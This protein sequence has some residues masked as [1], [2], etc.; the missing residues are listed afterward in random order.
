MVGLLPGK[1]QLDYLRSIPRTAAINSHL[2]QVQTP[3]SF[4]RQFL[5]HTD[6]PEEKQFD[7]GNAK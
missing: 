5:G 7:K 1:R 3:I 4:F 6:K 2:P